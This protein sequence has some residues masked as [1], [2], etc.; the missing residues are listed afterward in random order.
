MRAAVLVALVSLVVVPRAL[1]GGPSLLIGATEDATK[2]TTMAVAKAQM[3]LL[4]AAGFRADRITME[5]SPGETALPASG[6]QV[7]ENVAAAAKLDAVT[8]VCVV[9]NHG[10][11]TTPLSPTDQADF[12]QWAASIA[13]AIPSIRIFVVGNEPNTNRYWLPQFNADGSDAAAPAY[14]SLLAQTYDALHAAAPGVTVLGGALDPRGGDNPAGARPTHSPTVFIHDLGEA[15]RASGRTTPIMDGFDHHPYEDNSSVAPAAGTHPNSTT[16]ALADYDKLVA[17]LGEAFGDAGYSLPIWYDEFGVETQIPAAEAS[18]Y[19]GTEPATVH[20][21]DE[22]TQAQYYRQA[23]QLAFCQPNV[24]AIMLF[25]SVDEQAL[26]GWQSGL[27]YA[28]TTTAKASLAATRLAMEESRRGVVAHCDGL[29]LPVTP[30]LAQTANRLTLTCTLDC[31][32]TAKLYRGTRLVWGVRARA[33]GG[34]P[35]LL[36]PVVPSTAGRYRVHLTGVN[37]VNPA[38]VVSRWVN[39]RRG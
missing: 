16:I 38:P 24:Q 29:Q 12:A 26:S 37:P 15:W 14:E 2:S 7:L 28:G 6:R 19:T 5:W 35:K 9:M 27:Y 22:A 3:D 25:H 30:R 20:P 13:A 32:Y 10:S 4:A 31:A 33:T 18:H 34:V 1:G 39:V 23:I 8:L 17:S 36:Q 11:A 21:V